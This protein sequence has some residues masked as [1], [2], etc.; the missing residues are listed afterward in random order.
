M[1]LIAIALGLGL[2][3]LCVI[4]AGFLISRSR[5][6]SRKKPSKKARA[7]DDTTESPVS[8]LPSAEMEEQTEP[9]W[10][11]DSA[12]QSAEDSPDELRG[13]TKQ[14]EI[15]NQNL[16]EDA[17]QDGEVQAGDF[18]LELNLAEPAMQTYAVPAITEEEG[19]VEEPKAKPDPD[20]VQAETIPADKPQNRT[21]S[22]AKIRKWTGPK[23]ATDPEEISVLLRKAKENARFVR[24]GFRAHMSILIGANNRFVLN[25]H[26]GYFWKDPACMNNQ[27]NV[28][29]A[30]ESILLNDLWEYE[31]ELIPVAARYLIYRG[32]MYSYTGFVLRILESET[33]RRF[34][35]G[36]SDDENTVILKEIFSVALVICRQLGEDRLL[37]LIKNSFAKPVPYISGIL[38]GQ[39]TDNHVSVS[40]KALAVQS[41]KSA[42][43]TGTDFSA[44][45]NEQDRRFLYYSFLSNLRIFRALR[46]AFRSDQTSLITEA[47]C[48][49]RNL[50][51]NVFMKMAIRLNHSLEADRFFQILVATHAQSLPP[52]IR[53]DFQTN[54]EF[55][56]N[57]GLTGFK[58]YLNFEKP[59]RKDFNSDEEFETALYSRLPWNLKELPEAAEQI[60]DMKLKKYRISQCSARY[61]RSCF[62]AG[63]RLMQKDPLTAKKL[64]QKL[65]ART[66][67]E[68]FKDWVE[69]A[70]VQS[71][72]YSKTVAI[73]TVKTRG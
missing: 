55:I 71:V 47:L 2:F 58:T 67:K 60:E 52:G 13:E 8:G 31:P 63:V 66:G 46:T 3:T 49:V 11:D 51:G 25:C 65:A 1:L 69:K 36:K 45:Q 72:L 42:D 32:K 26:P 22:V 10:T 27:Q 68:E 15:D 33:G 37:K 64:F 21:V 18:E 40:L 30:C 4:T 23:R 43:I 20:P 62:E 70:Q 38:S 24:K 61:P 73:K 48:L 17:G 29:D 59:Q 19:G 54:F 50:S 28:F 14:E 34:V 6:R 12:N 35:Q 16:E 41:L 53:L 39:K 44:F 56:E 7:S 57:S 5:S 9:A